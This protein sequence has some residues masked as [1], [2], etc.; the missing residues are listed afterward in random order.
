MVN[1]P[2][3]RLDLEGTQSDHFLVENTFSTLLESWLFRKF[4]WEWV[5]QGSFADQKLKSVIYSITVS[6]AGWW[7]FKMGFYFN[8]SD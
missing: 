3:F 2:G 1:N 5:L 8:Y 4:D 6:F 7:E